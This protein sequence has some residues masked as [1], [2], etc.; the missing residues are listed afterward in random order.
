M[1]YKRKLLNSLAK[2]LLTFCTSP[3]S[4]V[5]CFSRDT[6]SRTLLLQW[7][8]VDGQSLSLS[9][10]LGSCH[11]RVQY[12]FCHSFCKLVVRHTLHVR[13]GML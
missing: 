12:D 8:D 7:Y 2:I 9:A 11:I 3:D 4:E 13:G 1:L 6:S 5:K 10:K